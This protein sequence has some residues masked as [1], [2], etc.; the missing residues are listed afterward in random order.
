MKLFYFKCDSS[1]IY[2]DFSKENLDINMNFNLL[3]TVVFLGL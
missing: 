3:K 1:N 2:I